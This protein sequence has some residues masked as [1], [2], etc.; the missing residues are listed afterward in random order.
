MNE[1]STLPAFIA[2][3]L[4]RPRPTALAERR[5]DRTTSLGSADVHRRAAAVAHALRARG[6]GRGDRVAILANNR[7]DWLLADFGILYAGG[8]VVPMYATTA[9]DQ[10]AFIFADSEAKLVF[11]DDDAVATRLRAADRRLRR[12]RRRW[13]RSVRA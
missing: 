8:V 4:A 10:I 6:V 5:G 2:E 9:D 11:V 12:R 13:V 1:L 3:H 7:V